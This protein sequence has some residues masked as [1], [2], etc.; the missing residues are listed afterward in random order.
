MDNRPV[1]NITKILLG[2]FVAAT[3]FFVAY[4]IWAT[5][6]NQAGAKYD[7]NNIERVGQ[8]VS[9][10]I[11]QM[12]GLHSGLNNQVPFVSQMRGQSM[13]PAQQQQ[14]L[15]QIKNSGEKPPV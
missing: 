14:A 12:F 13:Q 11:M 15:E 4:F 2:L 3:T 5:T 1:D 10:Q 9:Q 8:L 7:L 6:Q